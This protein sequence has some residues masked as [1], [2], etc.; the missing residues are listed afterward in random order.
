VRH[1]E[2]NLRKRNAQRRAIA[3][4]AVCLTLA[5]TIKIAYA[6]QDT[7]KRSEGEDKALFLVAHTG[8]G[9]PFFKESVVLMFPTSA[10]KSPLTVG[11]IVNKPT[12]VALSD[13]FPDDT[14]M[15]NVTETAYFGGPV[16]P[17]IA[18]VVFR[19]SEA[20]KKAS[21]LFGDVYVTFEPDF[22]KE[23]LKKTE[24]RPELRLFIGRAQ[25]AP[26]QLQGEMAAGA[27]FG[28]P[29]ETGI[30]F[31]GKPQFLWNKMN[32][33]V[34]HGPVAAMPDARL[35]FFASN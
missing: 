19:A 28:V 16:E 20:P 25:W 11:L 33:K 30:I 15:K 32:D 23:L 21:L 3:A 2:F 27:W 31:D 14:T 6:A 1:E 26:G 22:V 34:E 4:L 13:I 12:H 9:D 35:H 29:A 8:L 24:K 5:A 18:G 7:P 17:K 10:T